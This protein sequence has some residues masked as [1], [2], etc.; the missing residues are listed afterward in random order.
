MEIYAILNFGLLTSAP[1][2][3]VSVG[4]DYGQVLGLSLLFYEAQRSGTLPATNRI[5]WRGNSAINDVSP[6][7]T[8]VSGGWYDAGGGTSHLSAEIICEH[9]VIVTLN[10]HWFMLFEYT[11][12]H[13]IFSVR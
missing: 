2:V 8:D 1:I 10:S 13:T 11:W 6:A 7:G 9:G 12:L 4:Y 5:S 3:T